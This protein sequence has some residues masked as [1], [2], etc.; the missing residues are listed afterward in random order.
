M[1]DSLD[2]KDNSSGGDSEKM[3]LLISN[4]IISVEA[5]A[6]DSMQLIAS[7]HELKSLTRKCK[8]VDGN[9]EDE[10]LNLKQELELCKEDLKRDE[11][12]FEEKMKILKNLRKSNKSLQSENV[13]LKQALDL[14]Q[15]KFDTL[16]RLNEELKGNQTANGL[17]SSVVDAKESIVESNHNGASMQELLKDYDEMC[18]VKDKLLQDK[19]LVESKFDQLNHMTKEQIKE[20]EIITENQKKKLKELEIGIRL[21]QEVINQVKK[22]ELTALNISGTLLMLFVKIYEPISI[23]DYRKI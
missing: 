9:T 6:I 12:I 7:L 21:K 16:L 10:I 15:G 2:Y 22:S 13:E 3:N 20:Y 4:L 17:K 19:L 5:N 11:E 8:I 23:H 14:I 1:R 18:I